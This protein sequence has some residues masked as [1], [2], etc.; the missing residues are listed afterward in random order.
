MT[1]FNV[2]TNINY[3]SLSNVANRNVVTNSERVT[4]WHT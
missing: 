4:K 2:T 3:S 1:T